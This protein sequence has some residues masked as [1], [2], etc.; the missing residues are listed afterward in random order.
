LREK[1]KNCC[2]Y[3]HDKPPEHY[4]APTTFLKICGKL[5]N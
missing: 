4:L 2:W 3:G 1:I 5:R